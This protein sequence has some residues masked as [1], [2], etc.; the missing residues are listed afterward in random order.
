MDQETPVGSGN[1][2]N[3]PQEGN[4]HSRSYSQPPHRL[5]R[6]QRAEMI[7]E[8]VRKLNQ[9]NEHLSIDGQNE[10][11][12]IQS[13]TQNAGIH[14]RTNNSPDREK[15][16]AQDPSVQNRR[17]GHQG[18]EVEKPSRG[19]QQI[20]VRPEDSE[21]VSTA[22]KL[23]L[24]EDE[25]ED[26][27]DEEGAEDEEVTDQPDM[28]TSSDRSL[29]SSRT[30]S[31][32]LPRLPA[33]GIAFSPPTPDIGTLISSGNGTATIADNNFIGVLSDRIKVVAETGMDNNHS[34]TV[35]YMVQT[36]KNHRIVHFASREERDAVVTEY[37]RS[38]VRIASTLSEQQ[39]KSLSTDAAIVESIERRSPFLP[40]RPRTK[41]VLIDRAVKGSYD[42]GLLAG[43][44]G[45]QQA[46]LNNVERL[47]ARNGTYLAR[48]EQNFM[49][50]VRTLI[51][52][53]SPAHARVQQK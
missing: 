1:H 17:I 47:L 51:P 10:G 22:E 38:S 37:R 48:D 4:D 5:T 14:I 26:I 44:D 42:K 36:L 25:G 28:V 35:S 9:P 49:E 40:L 43:R 46:T 2:N 6:H 12:P 29:V 15:Q 33:P 50:K 13:L 30:R 21:T 16:V 53:G 23:S 18:S 34:R 39:Q 19:G 20:T 7:S 11:F 8:E 32:I 27:D 52:S 41:E 24:A 45:H 31:R 3:G